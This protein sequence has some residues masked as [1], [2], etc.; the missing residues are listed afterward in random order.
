MMQIIFAT[1][2]MAT[3]A[4]AIMNMGA[5]LE[6]QEGNIY[7]GIADAPWKFPMLRRKPLV[8]EGQPE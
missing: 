2:T 5:M 8:A 7:R 4:A 3:I 6:A 1:K